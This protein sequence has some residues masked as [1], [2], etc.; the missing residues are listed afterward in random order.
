MPSRE[1]SYHGTLFSENLSCVELERACEIFRAAWGFS[2]M[3]RI[4]SFS[5]GEIFVV[6]GFALAAFLFVFFFFLTGAFLDSRREAGEGLPGEII[7]VSSSVVGLR[8]T[9]LTTVCFASV[10][11]I[12]S[13]TAILQEDRR[14]ENIS[15][16]LFF[17]YKNI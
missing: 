14:W 17:V 15:I 4:E 3:I 8:A 5:G 1:N 7:V 13:L 16:C 6:E 10:V 9:S 2:V 11:G 12:K